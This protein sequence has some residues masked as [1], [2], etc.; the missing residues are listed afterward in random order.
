MY[1]FHAVLVCIFTLTLLSVSIAQNPNVPE[2]AAKIETR[3]DLT[4]AEFVDGKTK[5]DEVVYEGFDEDLR[6]YGVVLDHPIYRTTFISEIK[7]KKA[8][9]ETGDVFSYE[10]VGAVLTELKSW[11]SSKGYL[12]ADVKALGKKVAWFR[13]CS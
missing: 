9:I 11:L 8:A 2:A 4:A 7:F 10:K 6:D 1:R 5:I 3:S 13:R 12:K